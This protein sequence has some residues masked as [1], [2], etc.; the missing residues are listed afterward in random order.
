MTGGAP[1]G[2]QCT[3]N[4]T[5]GVSS[6][7]TDAFGYQGV[8][9]ATG[10]LP[11]QCFQDCTGGVSCPFGSTCTPTSSRSICIPNG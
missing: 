3:V 7:P 10:S 11:A 8:C 4:C 5:P 9:V 1:A 6:C 2:A